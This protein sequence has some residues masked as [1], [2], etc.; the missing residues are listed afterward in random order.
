MTERPRRRAIWIAVAAL[1]A[2]VVVVPLGVQV[3]GRLIRQ[4]RIDTVSYHRPIRTLEIDSPGGAVT[5]GAGPA[6][7]VSVRRT[8]TWALSRPNVRQTWAGDTLRVAVAC[9]RAELYHS[10]ECGVGLDLRV[11]ADVAVRASVAS[12]RIDVRNI[13]GGLHLRATAGVVRMTGVSGRVWARSDSGTITGTALTAP[14]VDAGVSSGAVRLGFSGPPERVTA[15]AASGAVSIGVPPGSRYRVGGT[16]GSGAR[17]VDPTLVDAG[18]SRAITLT[19]G[20]GAVTLG[21]LPPS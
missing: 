11:P 19:T 13:A 20:S 2:F 5:V 8:L 6:G 7:Q 17:H 21:P 4:T 9:R 15:T 10:L 1:T 18:S 14:N 16:T 3:W 12:G